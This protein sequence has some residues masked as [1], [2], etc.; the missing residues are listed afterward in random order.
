MK[1]F[2]L[3]NDILVYGTPLPFPIDGQFARQL[4]QQRRLDLKGMTVRPL[5]DGTFRSILVC[6][7]VFLPGF[8]RSLIPVLS[9]CSIR[10]DRVR[11]VHAIQEL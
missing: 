11:G 5:Q 2:F 9:H 3:F 8:Q 1:M 6:R 10:R 4:Q 7:D